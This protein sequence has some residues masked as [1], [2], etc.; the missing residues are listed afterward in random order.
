MTK[1]QVLIVCTGN[2]CRSQMAEALWRQEAADRYEVS[3]AGTHPSGVHP[4]ARLVIEELGIDMSDHFSKSVY[5]VAGQPFDLVITVCDDAREICPVF[6]RASVQLH[7]PF[8]DP[9]MSEGSFDERLPLFR[10]TRD[11]IHEKIR[12]FLQGESAS[13]A[14]PSP[15]PA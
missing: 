11:L 14:E 10:R 2:A 9:V 1:K 5:D 8:E 13:S 6:L 15:P 3:S 4:L 7:W 12:Q